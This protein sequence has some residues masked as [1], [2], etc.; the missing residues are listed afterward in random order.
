MTRIRKLRPR[1]NHRVLDRH[2]NIFLFFTL[3]F[4][5]ILFGTAE[6]HLRILLAFLLALLFSHIA[7]VLNWLTLDGAVAATVFGTIS[8]GLGG[9]LGA[10]VVL[11]FFIS[12]SV[13]SK[14]LI[15]T[16]GF[17]EKKFRRDGIQVWSNGFWFCLWVIIWYLSK[18]DGFMIAAVSSMAMATA[19][20]WSSEVGAT[21]LK[22]KTWLI[23]TGRK[24]EPGT[25]GGISLAGSAAAFLGA[26]LIA[27]IFWLIA[28]TDSPVAI[29]IILSIG[30]AGS[31]IDSWLGARF[32]NETY[33]WRFLSVIGLENL[34]VSNN[35][36]NWAA[37][38]L[39]S[40]ISLILILVIGV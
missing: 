4:V 24:V 8:F 14:D 35:F 34:Y 30:F 9:F 37:A 29:L 40:L 11:T 22:A 21:R 12:G 1:Q 18:Y 27:S 2:V 32:Q 19:D 38:G 6:I 15:T 36:V 5:F 7:F 20:T 3:I 26:A 25:D 31:F 28:V 13:L 39:A 23:T 10:A 33:N 17:L 16:E